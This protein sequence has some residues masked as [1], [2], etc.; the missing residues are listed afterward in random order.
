MFLRCLFLMYFLFQVLVSQKGLSNF[1]SSS[2]DS[3]QY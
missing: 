2:L 1:S 3:G